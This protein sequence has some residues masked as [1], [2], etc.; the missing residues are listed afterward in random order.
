MTNAQ[1]PDVSIVLVGLNACDFI[2][3]CVQSVYA[4]T[5]RELRYEVI[6]VDNGSRDGTM[7]MLRAEFPQ[8]RTLENGAN[9]GFCKAANQGAD[10]A[11]GRHFFFLNDDTVVQ[12]DAIA[13]LVEFLDVRSDAAAVGSR[14]LNHDFTDQWSGRRFPSLLNGIFGRR[15][16]LSRLFP[17][18][19]PVVRYLYKDRINQAEPFEVDWVSAAA[20]MV[21]RSAFAAVGGFAEDYYYWHEPV[22]CDRLRRAGGEIYLHPRS[23][24]VHFEGHGS[25]K[26][27]YKMRRNLII[28]FHRGAYRCYCEHHNLASLHPMRWVAGTALALRAVMLVTRNRLESLGQ[29]A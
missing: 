18:A 11:H 5:W 23:R 16:F 9:L 13:L 8:V 19:P 10:M 4:A 14:L 2:R 24:I 27:P 26:R 3:Q 29:R 20:M 1:H 15:S 28:D 22:I 25:G 12:D 7:A 21:R 17:D 6:Y